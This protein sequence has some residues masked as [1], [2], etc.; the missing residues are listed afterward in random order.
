MRAGVLRLGAVLLGAVFALPV[1]AQPGDAG[2]RATF[3]GSLNLQDDALVLRDAL[4]QAFSQT[5]PEATPDERY[6]RAGRFAF[7]LVANGIDALDVL[8]LAE[9][10]VDVLHA[11]TANERPLA[12][13][14][15]LA[16][17]VI[18]ADVL[19]PEADTADGYDGGVRVR[20]VDV[21]KGDVPA[22]TISVRQQRRRDVPFVIGA[23]YLLLVSNG[24][25]RYGLHRRGTEAAVPEAERTHRFS[26]YRQYLM[27]GEAVVWSGYSAEDTA[28]ALDEVRA[29]DAILRRE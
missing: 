10:G 7:F 15:L 14:S 1:A 24:I 28:R 8:R 13:Q 21:V 20:V 22:D 6:E 11:I 16:D 18:V 17:L 19:A 23:R 12:E 25:Y 5:D 3:L 29:V 9:G 4:Y 2:Q 26:I 27:D